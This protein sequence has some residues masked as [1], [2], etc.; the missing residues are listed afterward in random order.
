ME[1]KEK[2]LSACDREIKQAEQSEHKQSVKENAARRAKA[3]KKIIETICE[4]PGISP[5][6][7]IWLLEETQNLIRTVTMNQ[8]I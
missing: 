1:L 4:I 3:R 5:D 6:S 8:K 2:I 7:A